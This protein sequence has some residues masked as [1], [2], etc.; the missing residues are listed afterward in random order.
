MFKNFDPNTYYQTAK[1][2]MRNIFT[3][4]VVC[5]I[6]SESSLLTVNRTLGNVKSCGASISKSGLIVHGEN[7][8]RGAFPWIVALMHTGFNPPTFICSG[9]LISKKIVISGNSFVQIQLEG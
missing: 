8:P 6:M 1:K 9:T 2:M 3:V 7:F 4:I 5:V